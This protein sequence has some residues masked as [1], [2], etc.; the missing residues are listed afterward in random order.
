MTEARILSE[1]YTPEEVQIL[2]EP[3]ERHL[4][5]VPDNARLSVEQ[6]GQWW[7]SYIPPVGGRQ[8]SSEEDLD[9]WHG[10]PGWRKDLYRIPA[11][12]SPENRAEWLR[13]L[14]L[15]TI[16]YATET[17]LSTTIDVSGVQEV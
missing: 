9:W 17:A 8:L 16:S 10:L 5:S 1:A 12:I 6:W 13:I 11:G 14:G 3:A 15:S 2:G 4:H 7:E